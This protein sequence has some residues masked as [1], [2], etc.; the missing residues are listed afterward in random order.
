MKLLLKLIGIVVG[1]FV[2]LLVAQLV[3]SESGEVVVVTIQAEQPEHREVRLWVV[4]AEGEAFL[5]AGSDQAGWYQ[6][7]LTAPMVQ[8][9]RGQET[10]NAAVIPEPDRKEQ[11]N[12]LMS[13]KYGWADTFIDFLFG[14]E[15]S[16]PLRL[17]RRDPSLP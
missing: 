13:Q 7:M 17:Q 12:D 4:D 11:I 15:D 2:A 14:R 3:A 16:V 8:V 9:V 1:L 10:F 6:Q 5:R